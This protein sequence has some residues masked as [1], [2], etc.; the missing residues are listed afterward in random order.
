MSKFLNN[1]VNGDCLKELKKIP[2]N[3]FDL[4]FADPPYYMQIGKKLVRPDSSK[5]NGV[6][7]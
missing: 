5:V 4:I 1:I 6:N 3:S 7:D 2:D